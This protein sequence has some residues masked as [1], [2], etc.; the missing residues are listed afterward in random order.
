[1][2]TVELKWTNRTI[3]AGAIPGGVVRLM[4]GGRT[5]YADATADDLTFT[6]DF[7]T[8]SGRQVIT[9][10]RT[11]ASGNTV[12]VS[13]TGMTVDGGASYSLAAETSVTLVRKTGTTEWAVVREWTVI[14]P[15]GDGVPVGCIV[16]W[17]GLV[18]DIPAGWHLCDGT[19]GTPDLRGKFIKGAAAGVEA[20][21]TGGGSY[22]PTGTNTLG[23]VASAATGITVADHASHTH[24]VTSSVSV[25]DHSVTQPTIAWPAGVPTI[26]G[27]AVS[28]HAAHTHSVTAAG[29]VSAPTFTGTAMGT[30]AHELPF[31]FPSTILTRQI[32]SA[33]FGTGTTRT[34][35]GQSANGSS[36]TT[37]AAVVKSEA[38]SA[39]TPAGTVSAPTFTGSGVTSG[40]PSA[41]LSHTVSSQGTIAWPAGVPDATGTAVSSHSVTNAEVVSGAPSATLAHSVT[42]AGHTH[43]F[44]QPTFTG[45]A[46]SPEPAYYTL[47]FIMRVS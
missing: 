4:D 13:S 14:S 6:L 15:G 37:T 3:V 10:H 47:C 32:G 39:G 34:A 23:A 42:D 38:V 29:T 44:T 46:A 19:G 18:A 1:V 36:N 8:D 20:G 30:H 5:V 41:T 7:P 16:M 27:I 2:T 28:D 26:S 21:D 33:I 9:I 31:Q 25:A 17:S 40:N 45:N 35:S 11:D 22:T 43:T 24:R 12:T